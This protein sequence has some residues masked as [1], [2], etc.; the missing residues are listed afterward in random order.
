MNTSVENAPV[1]YLA[2]DEITKVMNFRIESEEKDIDSLVEDILAN[3]LQTPILVHRH[4]DGLIEIVQGHRRNLSC[5]Q[6]EDLYS[7]EFEE[8]FPEGIPCKVLSGLDTN[9]INIL[10]ADSGN[11]KPLRNPW[12]LQAFLNTQYDAGISMAQAGENASEIMDTVH[13]LP[14]DVQKEL[15]DYQ[16]DIDKFLA[17]GEQ[18]K[19]RITMKDKSERRKKARHGKNQNHKAIYDGANKVMA[20]FF[21][22]A[23]GHLPPEGHPYHVGDDVP[24]PQ[25]WTIARA[26]KLSDI[27][28]QDVD[29]AKVT[30]DIVT[31]SDPGPMFIQAWN[32][33]VN[34]DPKVPGERKASKSYKAIEASLEGYKSIT[35]RQTAQQSMGMEKQEGYVKRDHDAYMME[36]VA[37]EDPD[38][39][40][41]VKESAER[42]RKKREADK[43]ASVQE[44]EVEEASASA[45]VE[46]VE[47]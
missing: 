24:M 18:A 12:E 2:L 25:K 6:I 33:W 3:G 35:A 46:T 38:L 1:E 47:G 41:L 16:A 9:A 27:Y 11:S 32:E 22:N 29:A 8:L 20:F 31:K 42:I 19:A 17:N 14:K 36:L 43:L 37:D 10:K 40:E 28:K 5:H 21:F 26:R 39:Y 45:E 13:P 44:S 30:G 4:D 34:E 15:N 23:N 7:D